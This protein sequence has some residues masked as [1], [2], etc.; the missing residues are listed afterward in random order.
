MVG[1]T[2]RSFL[3]LP[4][5]SNFPTKLYDFPLRSACGH[6]GTMKK[7][8]TQWNVEV[9][10]IIPLCPSFRFVRKEFLSFHYAICGHFGTTAMFHFVHCSIMPAKIFIVPL[11]PHADILEGLLHPIVSTIPW[12]QCFRSYHSR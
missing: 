12:P 2:N 3:T 1:G 9:V 5:Y 7:I 8:R 10:C 11:Y 4:L 6:N